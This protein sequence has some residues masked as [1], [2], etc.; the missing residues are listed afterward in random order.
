MDQA[1]KRR[2]HTLANSRSTLYYDVFQ[3][4]FGWFAAVLSPNGLKY[5]SLKSTPQDSFEELGPQVEAAQFDPDR[6]KDIRELLQ[7]FL[8]GKADNL[9]Q[10]VL[11][12][13]DAPDFHKRAWEACRS[14]PLG[15]TRTYAWLAAM[16]GR[17]G[18]YRAAGQAMARNRVPI[19]VPCHRVIGSDGGLH[20]YGA[21][22]L[23][24]KAELLRMETLLLQRK[25][26][27][28]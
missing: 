24:V 12:M 10:I 25:P 9:D 7:S 8:A 15:E 22:G 16:A 4:R 11:D 21:G 23:G 19:V 14:I 3:T 1:Q 17:P 28:G 26:S 2:A 6:L 20:G 18:A 27:A 5:G 13:E